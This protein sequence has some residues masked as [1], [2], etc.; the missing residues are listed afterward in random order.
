MRLLLDTHCVYW[1]GADPDRLSPVAREAVLDGRNDL[2]LSVVA[3]V[4]LALKVSGGKLRL[5][6][7]LPEFLAALQEQG[8]MRILPVLQEHALRTAGLPL[9]HGDPFDRLLVA[10]ALCEGVPLVTRDGL[11][12]DYGIHALW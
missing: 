10:Q 11:L 6:R 3:T 7:P 8:G 9:L 12:A 4:E 5:P 1:M 2:L